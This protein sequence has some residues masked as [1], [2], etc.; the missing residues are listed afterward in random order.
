MATQGVDAALIVDDHSL[1]VSGA[2]NIIRSEA[3]LL[4]IVVCS[5]AENTLATLHQSSY[6]WS[7][8]LLDLDVPG[9][10]GLSLAMEIKALG[11]ESVTCI[12][13]GNPKT[14]FVNQARAKGF[15]GYILKGSPLESLETSL[16]TV[17]A[18]YTVFPSMDTAR[19]A[20][21]V[22]SMTTRQM[23]ILTQVAKGHTSKDIARLFGLTPFTV[24]THIK[25]ILH[26]LEVNSR[27]H[28]VRE[29]IGLGLLRIDDTA[30]SMPSPSNG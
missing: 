11:L 1:I 28:A 19:P 4:E 5:D 29:A 20:A 9:A 17:L 25:A 15:R 12:L 24:D 27:A 18:G 13:T 6:R 7:L 23:Q 10:I 26:A 21:P 2:R 14:E 30:L 16:K 3:P 8:I 22:K